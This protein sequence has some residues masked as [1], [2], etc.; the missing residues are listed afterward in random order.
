VNQVHD[1]NGG[2]QPSGLFWVVQLPDQAFHV[3]HDGRQA[4]LEADHVCVID[5]FQFGGPNSVPATVNF[6]IKWDAI[7]PRELHG[8]GKAVAPT[9]PAAFLGRFAKARSTAS[10]SGSELGFSFRSNPGVNTDRTFAELGPE[11]NGIFL[12]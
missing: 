11:Q 8:R 10:F 3:S 12:E 7:G 5:S 2:I 6:K 9:D 1:F 4:S